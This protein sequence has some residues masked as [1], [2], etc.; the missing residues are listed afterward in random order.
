MQGEILGYLEKA[1]QLIPDE[2]LT[3]ECKEMVDNYYPILMG[4]LTG[5]LVSNLSVFVQTSKYSLK[6]VF[7]GTG[8]R[9][10]YLLWHQISYLINDAVTWFALKKNHVTS[11]MMF[12]A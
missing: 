1:C 11:Q 8:S 3:A 2:G 6:L 5:E 4:I 9:P 7:K 10:K 12:K